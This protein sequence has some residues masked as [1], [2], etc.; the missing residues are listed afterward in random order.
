MAMLFTGGVDSTFTSL[1]HHPRPQTL[2]TV[3][4]NETALDFEERW[5][6]LSSQC[7]SFAGQFGHR[8][9]FIKTNAKEIVRRK[10]I[11]PDILV[12]WRNVQQGMG[13]LGL[14][15]PGLRHLGEREIMIAATHWQCGYPGAAASAPEID[16]RVR[17]AGI[18]AHQDGFEIN[19]QERLNYIV[20]KCREQGLPMPALTVCSRPYVRQR[21]CCECDKCLRTMSGVLAAGGRLDEFGFPLSD[22]ELIDQVQGQFG[23]GRLKIGDSSTKIFHWKAVQEGA[24]L[25]LDGSLG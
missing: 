2:I 13:F 21:N 14:C 25:A 15:M 1:Y 19:R 17:C 16:N 4:G 12:W 5:R 10:R 23:S 18:S 9:F 22:D 6:L 11:G 8:N 20:K 7:K 3:W 24:R